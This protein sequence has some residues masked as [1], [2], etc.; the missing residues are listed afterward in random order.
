MVIWDVVITPY[1]EISETECPSCSLETL[2]TQDVLWSSSIFAV[3]VHW[4]THSAPSDVKGLATLLS[5]S[6][7]L[8]TVSSLIKWVASGQCRCDMFSKADVW[9]YR[10]RG[11]FTLRLLT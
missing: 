10:A 7:T 6:I 5:P 11:H 2:A 4:A 1:S 9:G 8:E 3:L